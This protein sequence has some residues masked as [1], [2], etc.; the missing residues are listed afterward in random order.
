MFGG[1]GISNSFAT[2]NG[3]R[4]SFLSS[5]PQAFKLKRES[6]TGRLQQTNNAAINANCGDSTGSVRNSVQMRVHRT[7]FSSMSTHQQQHSSNIPHHHR[8]GGGTSASARP[9]ISA[10]CGSGIR[11]PV[12]LRALPPGHHLENRRWSLA[13]L[14][15]SSGYGTPGTNS[16]Y[17][18]Q[19]SSQENL[20]SIIGD[21]RIRDRFDSNESYACC[22]GDDF[23]GLMRPRSRSLTSP[24]PHLFERL[25]V[26]SPMMLSSVYKER[27]PKAKLQMENRLMQFLTQNAQLS[28]FTSQM[29]Q[30]NIVPPSPMPTRCEQQQSSSLVP[31]SPRPQSPNLLTRPLSPLVTESATAI[32][33]SV[34]HHRSSNTNFLSAGSAGGFSPGNSFFGGGQQQLNQGQ[35]GG[36]GDQLSNNTPPIITSSTISSPLFGCSTNSPPIDPQLL[37]LISDGATR[38]LHHQLCEIAADCLQKSRDDLLNCV[39]FCSMSVRL[40]ETLAEAEMKVGPESYKYLFRLVKQMLMIVSRTARLLECLEFN[41]DEFYQLLG[42]AEVAVREQLGSGSARV[43]DLPQYILTKLGLNKNLSSLEK[44]IGEQTGDGAGEEEEE[45]NEEEFGQNKGQK[46]AHLTAQDSSDKLILPPQTTRE[47]PK[48]EDFENIRLISNGA[49]GAVYLVKHKKTRQRF[50][51][52][53][54]KKHTLLLRNQVE[55]VYAERDILTFTDN[56]FVVC[57]YG[58]FETKQH[59]CMLM[60]YVEGGDCASLLKSAGTL[61]IELARLYVAETVMAVEYLHSCGIVHRDLKPDNLLITSMGHIKLTDFG[62]SKIGLMNRTTLVSE[63]YLQDDTQQFKDN[64]LCGTPEYIAPE[65]ILRQGYGK[66]VDWWALGVILYEF[67]VGIVPFLGDSPEALFANI[68]NEEVEYPEGEEAL[69]PDAESLIRMLLEK[70]PA[71]RLG[72]MGGAGQVSSHPFFAPIDFGTILRQKAE[73]VPQLE[74]DEDTSYFD[75]RTDRYNHD[76]ESEVAEDDEQVPMFWSFSTAS[77]RHSIVGG[78]ELPIGGMAML[79]AAHAAAI[80]RSQQQQLQNSQQ[81]QH[82]LDSDDKASSGVGS[83]PGSISLGLPQQPSRCVSRNADLL[84]EPTSLSPSE[85]LQTRPKSSTTNQR[86]NEFSGADVIPSA[87]ILRRRFSSQR[88]SNTTNMSTSSS[89]TTGTGAG[90]QTTNTCSST[91]SSVDVSHFQYDASRKSHGQLPRLAISPCA[92]VVASSN[93][94]SSTHLP[95]QRRPEELLQANDHHTQLQHLSPVQERWQENSGGGGGSGG[96]VVIRRVQKKRP[97]T[98]VHEL[99]T[100]SSQQQQQQNKQQQQIPPINSP[101]LNRQLRSTS[102]RIPNTTKAPPETLKVQIPQQQQQTS[103][104]NS[105]PQTSTTNTIYY[106]SYGLNAAQQVHSSSSGQQSPSCAS[107]S[108]ASSY[109]CQKQQQQPPAE[110]CGPSLEVHQSGHSTTTLPSPCSLLPPPSSLHPINHRTSISGGLSRPIVIR[111]GA[112]GFGFTIRSVRVYLSE[113]SE[114][115]SIEHIV[116]AVRE[117]SPAW[118]AGLRVNDLI[119]HVHTQSVHNMTHPQLMHRLLSCGNELT[120]HVVPLT[121]T[122]IKEG[123]PRR[124]VGKPL[125]KKPLRRPTTNLRGGGG[126][127]GGGGNGR[128]KGGGGGGGSSAAALVANSSLLRRLSGKRGN[129]VDIVPGT[130]SQKQ[131]F[132]P[133]SV[134]SQEGVLVSNSS[135]N[136]ATCS[137]SSTSQEHQQQNKQYLTAPGAELISANSTTSKN[138]QTTKRLSIPSASVL[139]DSVRRKL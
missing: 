15:S 33:D 135:S 86:L 124:N 18:S 24:V 31:P 8:G 130:S 121:N 108:S 9:S 87:V 10:G 17:S 60:E 137:I 96:N 6:F 55:Q 73:F 65:V 53:K 90:G 40:D 5:S 128:V 117:G 77:P 39:Y 98:V 139:L 26:D 43:P 19:Y 37:R 75:S 131:T 122:S 45:E 82:D 69:N 38:F 107:V 132:M 57:F 91:D 56:P 105:S 12:A 51:L 79:Q 32:G 127:N 94:S 64:Q 83:A 67:L 27:F 92:S 106:H 111:K 71:D 74:N 47:A 125:R 3:S 20:A 48:E 70:N 59:L 133:R 97:S 66:P 114:Y 21:M 7:S 50:A 44:N 28:G 42:D 49:Y 81:Q 99:I 113:L 41:P 76:A 25:G 84:Q 23:G 54:M 118:E 2:T 138:S 103:S 100:D 88:H 11:Q 78:L 136:V 63:G 80:E 72:T 104:N 123:E 13:S 61:P 34:I 102:C 85:Q 95:L 134:S 116:S 120:V 93:P 14:P 4:R 115:Y 101:Q 129:A 126:S 16:A 58:S 109:E 35:D 112:Q 52:K 119:S 68:I 29:L 36:N 22:L 46:D 110:P 62:L 89:G 30:L 1:G